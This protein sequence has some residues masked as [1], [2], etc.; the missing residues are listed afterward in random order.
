M[1]T[2]AFAFG[3]HVE[4]SP[5]VRTM[6]KEA[7]VVAPWAPLAATPVSAA[8]PMATTPRLLQPSRR[9]F[10][11][12]GTSLFRGRRELPLRAARC[13]MEKRHT[14]RAGGESR[15]ETGAY[16]P[17]TVRRAVTVRR[18]RPTMR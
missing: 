15:G 6:V 16:F 8:A 4:G 14:V 2:F 3:T 9:R 18:S 10:L 11:M 7:L 17:R 1:L 5:A 12:V 13:W